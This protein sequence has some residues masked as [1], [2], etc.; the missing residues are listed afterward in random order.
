LWITRPRVAIAATA[1]RVE[2]GGGARL[3]PDHRL[4][5]QAAFPIG[6]KLTQ[7]AQLPPFQPLR[8]IV[9]YF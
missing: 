5:W 9:G 2:V 1:G 4:R 8:R 7:R 3:K 6:I